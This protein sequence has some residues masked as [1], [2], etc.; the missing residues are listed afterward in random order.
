M[1]AQEAERAVGLKEEEIA[2]LEAQ[3]AD[4][5]LYANAQRAAEINRAYQKAQ[6]ELPLL[7]EQWEQAEAAL[8]SEDE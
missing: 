5:E 4:P 3:M 1:R 2:Q 8:G 6:A 7:Y